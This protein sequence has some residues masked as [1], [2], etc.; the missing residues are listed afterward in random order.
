M[1][2]LVFD[3]DLNGF[4]PAGALHE[5]RAQFTA[6]T[7]PDGRVI[8]IGGN[9]A[10]AT[11]TIE[12]WDPKT[13]TFTYAPYKLTKARGWHGSALVRDGTIL[14]LGGYQN[15]CT[16]T[17]TVDQIDP[18]KGTVTTFASL[19]HWNTEL[20]AVTLLDGS[21]LG[22]GGGECGATSAYPDLDFLPGA[23]G[24]R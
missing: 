18:V 9:W 23:P 16:P 11:D 14:T 22:V 4:A 10:P 15:G 8:V 20:N 12:L 21:I 2:A 19:P 13:S 6:H 24:P 1:G 17:N 3:P 5:M 7:L